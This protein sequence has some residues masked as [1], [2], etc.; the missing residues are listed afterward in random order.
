MPFALAS[1][2]NLPTPIDKLFTQL[3]DGVRFATA[4][5]EQ[6]STPTV[7]RLG[8]NII[9]QTGLFEVPCRDWRSKPEATK[10]LAN[11]ILHFRAAD[12]DRRLTTVLVDI[13]LTG[14]SSL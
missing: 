2:W 6:P 3:D 4:G 5:N 11:F 12:Q 1:P 9:H 14:A 7:I 8:Y 10:T 13:F